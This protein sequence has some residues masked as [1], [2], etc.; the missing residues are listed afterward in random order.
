M[1]RNI[2]SGCCQSISVTHVDENGNKPQKLTARRSLSA[3]LR[4]VGL[5]LAA[6]LGV[7]SLYLLSAGPAYKL[8]VNGVIRD[9]VFRK[10]YDP[11]ITIGEATLKPH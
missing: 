2:K 1:N 3:I 5:S 4:L 9:S 8:A 10:A 6:A 7:L 11:A